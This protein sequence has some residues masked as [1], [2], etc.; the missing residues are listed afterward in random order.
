MT[1]EFIIKNQDKTLKELF[2]QHFAKFTGWAETT[3]ASENKWMMYFKEGT[4]QYGFNGY[5]GWCE[6]DL[7]I[8]QF[9]S[10]DEMEADLDKVELRLTAEAIRRGY[11]QGLL[12]QDIYNGDW[13]KSNVKISSDFFD[14]E[15][16]KAGVNQG[17]MALRDSNGSI[18]FHNG[19]WAEIVNTMTKEEAELKFNIVIR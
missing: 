5:G 17:Q 11:K 14:Y 12:I 19:I 2:P 7:K 9:N 3:I 8:Y 1:K 15:T 10:E 6:N 4:I 16:I 18:I 13:D